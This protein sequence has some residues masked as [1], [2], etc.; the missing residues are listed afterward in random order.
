MDKNRTIF[1]AGGILIAFAAGLLL[2][3][4]IDRGEAE[5]R[6]SA[7]RSLVSPSARERSDQPR[8]PFQMF[9]GDDAPRAERETSK[10][11]AFDRLILE[12]N[13]SA[14]R[15]C[16]Q[17]TRELDASGKTNY[18]DYVRLTPALKPAVSVAGQSLC[19]SGI[20]FDKEYKARVRAG[21]PSK[22]GEKLKRPVEVT[23]AFGDK[24]AYV[25]F[26]GDGV[27]LPRLEADG[28]GIET[29]NVE[30][31][32]ISVYRVS[33]R[34]LARKSIAQGEASPEGDYF[35]VW[36]QES[37]EDV[38]VKVFDKDLT[39]KKVENDTV[40]TVFPLGAALPDLKPGAYFVRLTDQTPGGDKYRKAQAWRWVMFTDLAMT[41]YSSGEGI[42]VFVRSIDTGRPLSGVELELVATNNDILARAVTAGDGRARFEKAAVNGDYPLTPRMIMAYGP[43]EDFAALDLSRAPLDLSDRNVDG[44]AAPSVLDAFIWLDRG[45]YRPGETA[46]VSGMLRDSAGL[47]ADRP[48]TVA[49]YRPNS[50]EALQQRVDALSIGGF[51]FDYEV[52][53]SAARGQWRI[54]VKADGVGVVGGET[55]SVEDFVPQRIEVKLN[56]DEEKP[57]R[58]GETRAVL[59][60]ARY[61]YGAPAGALGVESEARLRLDPNPFPAL[62]GYRYGPVNGRFDE[63]YLTLAKATTDS[64]GKASVHLAIEDAPKNYG[65]PL[66]ADLVVG[67]VEP[68]GRAVRESA[69]IPVRPD[70]RYVGLKLANDGWGFGQNEPA[71]I[72]A[73][74]ID[75]NG[76]QV[77]GDVEWRI[78]EEDY[79]F[80]WYRENGEWR[81]RRSY[82]D[83]LVA[84]GRTTAK[85]AGAARIAQALDTGSYR[86]TATDPASGA[87]T[88]I[89]FYVGW[90]SYESGADTPDQ[91][92]LT[93]TSETVAPGARARLFLDPPY[94]GEAIIAIATDKV[95]L[96]QRF[97]VE[98]KGREIIVDTDPSW[99][100][101]FYVMATIVTPRDVVKRPIPRRAM[102]VA[103]VPFDMGA[104][105]MDVAL[106]APELVRPRQ[107][108]TMPVKIDGVARGE[109]VMLTVAAVDEGI[110]RLT[111]F[112]SPDP[113]D[114]Y[115]SKKRLGVE[116]RDDYGRIL[117]ANLGAATRF[118]GDQLGGE[119]L[120]VVPVKSVALFNGLVQVNDDGVAQVPLDIPDF[121][122]ELRLMAVA[123]SKDK[124]GSAAQ[125][126][127][128]RD[129]VPAL[130]S[131]PRF[132]GPN[133]KASATLL[134]D[135]VDGAAGDYVIAV[136]GDDP[137]SADSSL[138]KSL[139]K[140]EQA[141]SL[142]PV[143]AGSVGVGGVKLSVTGPANFAVERD[144]PIQVRTPYF[145][146]TEISTRQL[147]PG[148]TVALDRTLISNYVPGSTAVSVSFSRLRG[149]D[150]G[151]LVDSLYRYPYGCSEQLTSTAMP[152][153]YLDALGGEAG[154]GPEFAVRPRVQEAVNQLLNRQ[155]P[156]GAFGLWREGDS[157]AQPWLG[158][159][160]TDFL[161]RA[162]AEG[163]GVPEDALDKAYDALAQVARVDRWVY[164]GYQMQ[165]YEGPWSNDTTEQLRRRSA[166]YA[167]YVL[168]R[169]GRADLSDLRYF[170]DALI[171]KTSSPLAKAHIGAALAM[172]GDRARAL[173]AFGKAMQAVGYQNTGDYYQTSL[174]DAAGVLALLAEV[175]NSP[176]VNEM[177]EKFV[178]LMK[179][180]NRM[181]TQEKAF[182]LL[183]AQ[184]MLRAGGPV[185]LT[186]DGNAVEGNSPAPR[187]NLTRDD[188]EKGAS[189]ANKGE[190]PLF[191][192]VSIY[193]SPTSP[194]PALAQGFSLTKRIATRDGQAV[195]P[196][197]IRQNDRLVI[198]I[199]GKADADRLHPAVIADL[200]PAGFEI[201]AVLRPED[202]AQDGASSGPYKWAGKLSWTKVAEARDDRF[203]A[204]IDLYDNR[205]GFTLAYLVRAVTPGDYVF[206]GA[207]I[208]DMYRPG[209]F[210]RTAV[211]KIK[212]SPAE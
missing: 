60:D 113:V 129:P 62:K 132:L 199:A 55:F 127:T 32:N 154:R 7:G 94:A 56:V 20:E 59:V 26:V 182:V 85:D 118:G 180:P 68:G 48:V 5:M 136:T 75:W 197:A 148:E 193:G 173:S 82:K 105:K 125:P 172:L 106:G 209:V 76:K 149:V 29:V 187:F 41:T 117:D 178:T 152:L 111:K 97:K 3:R 147:L 114:F 58:S 49:I 128:V 99:G 43:Q 206:P 185:S 83:I 167:L 93:V 54:E 104:R 122:G 212:I 183:A 150:P 170:H 90:R 112:A 25:G 115:Y 12:T 207:V 205:N 177:S 88:D 153:L 116:V 74:L 157:S 9:R 31:I 10:E 189:F 78:V 61:L 53:N 6:V 208:E 121:N 119:G 135:N 164:I 69:R 181:H 19:L 24:P 131:L 211:S 176:G 161:Y 191:A 67:V 108:V 79:W 64:S 158:A 134:I 192:S 169:A 35:Y 4:G 143:T 102:G 45:I 201:E 190:G 1:I 166:A 81:W 2:G 22:S 196:T 140:T 120:T 210:A 109:D 33:D 39:V 50:T 89:R 126:M 200:L 107:K 86:L 8:R 15:A 124:L 84:E 17:F 103:Y 38:G 179:D 174:R 171:D 142:F 77:A 186:R 72:D 30:K 28:L 188:L 65:A 203:V 168:A 130:L 175:Q 36:D 23:I 138:T 101:G 42:D 195:D 155:G 70:D 57:I 139:A 198:V 184:S 137:V 34:S 98:D 95:H 44:R 16:L 13:G 91:A 63:R 71:E 151:P 146:V 144:Y 80:D 194:P 73:V 40:T 204:A 37:G 52:P 123:W 165:A 11:F 202:G 47:A 133:D 159:Y 92:T 100:S 160:V 27:I 156:D 163:Y 145:P 87:K 14:P 21:T 18:A 141:T 96:V 66:R 110:L 46:H 51:S 162:K